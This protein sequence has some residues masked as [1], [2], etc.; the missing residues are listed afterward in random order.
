MS[1][2]PDAVDCDLE[3]AQQGRVDS[4]Y[5]K[6]YQSIAFTIGAICRRS[7]QDVLHYRRCPRV[8]STAF[9]SVRNRKCFCAN[10]GGTVSANPR[11]NRVP[12]SF[13]KTGPRPSNP[14]DDRVVMPAPAMDQYNKSEKPQHIS[15]I[16]KCILFVLGLRLKSHKTAL[17]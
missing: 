12:V 10:T 11:L 9:V 13:S 16:Y 6:T 17:W 3:V 4:I 14:G 5:G 15:H 2:I 8:A 7:V 1:W